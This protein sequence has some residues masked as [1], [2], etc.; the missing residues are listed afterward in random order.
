MY[1]KT[2]RHPNIITGG[3]ISRNFMCLAFSFMVFTF[4]NMILASC[5]QEEF[6]SQEKS[7]KVEIV[8]SICNEETRVSQTGNN[9]FTFDNGDAIHVIGWYAQNEPWKE[10]PVQWW[11]NATSTYDGNR[12][13]TEPYMRWQHNVTNHF[14]AWYPASFADSMED[15]TAVEFDLL[16]T[17]VRDV[18]WAK[19]S[20]VHKSGDNRLLLSFNHLM[21]RFEVRLN[22]KGQYKDVSNITVTATDMSTSATV[23][24][25]SCATPQF[26]LYGNTNNLLLTG[27]T[28]NSS[29]SY[30]YLSSDIV[31]PQKIYGIQ[32][33]FTHGNGEVAAMEYIHQNGMNLISGC[34][35]T[36]TLNVGNDNIALDGIE[37]TPWND[38]IIEVG[39]AEEIV[40]PQDGTPYLTFTA[41]AAQTA[42]VKLKGS[43]TLDGSLQYSVNDGSWEELT[44]N[45]AISFGGNNGNLRIR[46]KSANGMATDISKYA[47]FTFGSKNVPVACFG[48]IRT[49]VDFENY[50][51]ADT[52]EARFCYMFN[53]CTNLTSAPE[54]PSGRLAAKCY[55]G[56]FYGCEGLTAAPILPAKVMAASCYYSMFYG[57]KG[58]TQAPELPATSLAEMCYY[59]MFYGCTGLTSAPELPAVSLAKSCYAN[60]FNGC[61]ALTSANTLPAA[62]LANNCYEKM[63]Y[64]CKG[65]TQAPA[66]PATALAEK[67]Y[68]YMF[69]GCSS[70]ASAP[71]L[72]AK[73]L[74]KSC[75]EY[76]FY[77]CPAL[78]AAPAL[79][80][81]ELAE[82]CYYSMFRK[83]PELT[84]APALPASELKEYCYYY[85]FSACTSLTTSPV[86]SAATLV[87]N[88]YGNMFYGCTSLNS[89]TMLATDISASGCLSNCLKNVSVNGT[90]HKTTGLDESALDRTKIGIPSGW[91][92]KDYTVL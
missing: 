16:D 19:T 47:Q 7:D 27:E 81:T 91:E 20:A 1:M 90:F 39:N 33:S 89:F 30:S 50:L 68:Y 67:S 85:M 35:H 70:L 36:L 79:P 73:S 38:K 63:F 86:L 14:L 13:E 46:G 53:G 28:E 41:D 64:G 77:D 59:N 17:P 74:A 34:H 51:T 65:L 31:I 92:I 58:L 18:L 69:S 10:N 42:T 62:V 84:S 56:M 40:I 82:R 6:L 57:C 9:K 83:C 5:E 43:Y 24:M 75:Y 71:E 44:A 29:A 72:P 60:M 12:W 8:A 26:S 48:D 80:A 11:N 21:S 61:T 2:R 15:L 25:I 22:F 3:S 55:F 52:G 4:A 32:L 49:L 45:T 88:C 66:L 87:K 78:T 23:D 37:V 54:L 76:M